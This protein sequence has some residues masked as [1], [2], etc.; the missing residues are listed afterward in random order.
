VG[1]GCAVL[2]V[3]LVTAIAAIGMLGWRQVRE[4][5]T[6]MKDPAARAAK[7][8]AMLGAE[9]LP[10]GLNA[11]LFLRLP[12]VLDLAMVSDAPESVFE[13]GERPF[14]LRRNL[15]T[16]LD[17]RDLGGRRARF[18]DRLEDERSAFGALKGVNI[19]MGFVTDKVIGHGKLALDGWSFVY[20]VLRGETRVDGERQP[21]TV[22][23]G[24]IRCQDDDGRLRILMWFHTDE[25]TPEDAGREQPAASAAPEDEDADA[26]G[27]AGGG[28][29]LGSP[30]VP[31]DVERLL[32]YFDPCASGA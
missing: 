24:D 23:M 8:R 19:D 28:A 17:M 29:Q 16:V 7:V 30:A 11:Q 6:S 14:S 26:S 9:A 2:G 4:I 1:C 13:K 20:Q 27:D 15:L 12:F 25:A 3:G 5:Q 31:A 10:P 22:A 18:R 32:A 21:G